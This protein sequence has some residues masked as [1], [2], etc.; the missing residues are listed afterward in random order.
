MC[1][2]LCYFKSKCHF[3]A[4]VIIHCFT[5]NNVLSHLPSNR[6]SAL[7]KIIQKALHGEAEMSHDPDKS[8]IAERPGH[9]LSYLLKM[10]APLNLRGYF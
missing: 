6:I 1:C 9:P 8:R 3:C 2:I 4:V 5:I 7:K 10:G